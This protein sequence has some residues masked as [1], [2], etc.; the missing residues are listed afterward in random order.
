MTINVFIH[1]FVLSVGSRTP[2][3]IQKNQKIKAV[4]YLLIWYMPDHSLKETNSSGS[5]R[6][7]TP[8]QLQAPYLPESCQAGGAGSVSFLTRI[9]SSFLTQIFKGHL[10]TLI[11]IIDNDKY[12]SV[13]IFLYLH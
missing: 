10:I 11:T 3:K 12:Y 7:Q 9:P 8:I 2:S 5:R 6:I 1:S 4:E 13:C